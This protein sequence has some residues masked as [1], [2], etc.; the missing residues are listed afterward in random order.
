[1]LQDVEYSHGKARRHLGGNR[2]LASHDCRAN[3]QGTVNPLV[4]M[5]GFLCS[6]WRNDRF[7]DHEIDIGEP[8]F[9]SMDAVEANYTFF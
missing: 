6:L 9:Q 2:A 8:P 1:V 5:P 4:D 7:L 3:E